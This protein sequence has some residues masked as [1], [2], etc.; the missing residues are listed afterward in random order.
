M[1]NTVI[2]KKTMNKSIHLC[3]SSLWQLLWER[4]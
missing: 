2:W 3:N 1:A 4:R